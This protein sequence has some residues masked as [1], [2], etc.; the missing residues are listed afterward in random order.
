MPRVGVKGRTVF[1][2][3]DVS[4]NP[5]GQT[6]KQT[7]GTAYINLKCVMYKLVSNPCVVNV[8]TG[9]KVALIQFSFTTFGSK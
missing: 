9:I 1:N 6:T 3:G 8:L 5:C 4:M 7:L 2:R